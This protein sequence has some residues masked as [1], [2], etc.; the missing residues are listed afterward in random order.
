MG[1]M[2]GQR[3]FAS[4]ETPKRSPHPD[5]ENNLKHS[6]V[7]CKNTEGKLPNGMKVKICDSEHLQKALLIISW[8]PG[9]FVK[10]GNYATPIFLHQYSSDF[11]KTTE[12]VLN[13]YVKT[14]TDH[15]KI[16][17]KQPEFLPPGQK[18]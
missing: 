10:R 11:R 3:H 9:V 6:E 16:N 13:F 1:S 12:N 2:V 15:E 4:Q 5:Y 8:T 17:P 14:V 7:L 18:V